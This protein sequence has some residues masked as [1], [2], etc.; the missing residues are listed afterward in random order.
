MDTVTRRI[1]PRSLDPLPEESLPGFIL[2]LAGRLERSPS[3]LATLCGLSG[4]NQRIPARYLFELPNDVAEQF[5]YTA[6]LTTTEVERLTLHSYAT[7]Y[8]VLRTMT[9]KPQRTTV[10]IGANWSMNPS[11]RYCRLCLR[12]DGSGIQN[13][14]GGTWKLN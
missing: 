13:S 5:A 10:M 11:S 1:L 3:R 7:A 8:P 6:R 9:Q 12:G 2:R 14:L 4:Y